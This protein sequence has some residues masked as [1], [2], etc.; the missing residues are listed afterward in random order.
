M[1]KCNQLIVFL[2]SPECVYILKS[3]T[4]IQ[5]QLKCSIRKKKVFIV[6]IASLTS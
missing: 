4:K 1:I 6:S 3:K 5:V 2:V